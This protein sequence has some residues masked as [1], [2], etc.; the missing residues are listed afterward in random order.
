M[1]PSDAERDHHP[2][3]ETEDRIQGDSSQDK[4]ERL[5]EKQNTGVRS[6]ETGEEGLKLQGARFKEKGSQEQS[7]KKQAPMGIR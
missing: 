4:G 7:S 3:K 5:K 1:S 6:Q 2:L